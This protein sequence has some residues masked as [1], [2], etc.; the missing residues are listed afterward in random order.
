[1][2]ILMTCDMCE[3]GGKVKCANARISRGADAYKG[4]TMMFMPVYK[5]TSQI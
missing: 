3:F 1:V 4:A 2:L 5:G